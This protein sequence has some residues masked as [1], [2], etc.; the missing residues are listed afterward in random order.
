MLKNVDK[1]IR[2]SKILES[3]WELE[4]STTKDFERSKRELESR[5]LE[6]G[7]MTRRDDGSMATMK[8]KL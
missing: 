2:V 7:A 5:G 4:L 1:V 8:T 3:S 6:Y